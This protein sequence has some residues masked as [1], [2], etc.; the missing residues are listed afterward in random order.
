MIHVKDSLLPRVKV[1]SLDF[2]GTYIYTY[3]FIYL[4]IYIYIYLFFFHTLAGL[5]LLLG[6]PFF[7]CFQLFGP[8]SV[9]AIFRNG[10]DEKLLLILHFEGFN[11]NLRHYLIS[12]PEIFHT[13][14]VFHPKN[15]MFEL[16]D[17]FLKASVFGDP[18]VQVST[19]FPWAIC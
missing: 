5:Q 4:S 11:K 18:F 16:G 13:D 15:A 6:G 8:S 3:I 19:D 17:T 1:W 7:F 9:G 2:L 14:T 12:P 10:T